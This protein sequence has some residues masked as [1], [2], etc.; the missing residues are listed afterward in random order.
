MTARD[1]PE[2]RSSL[3]LAG[4]SILVVEDSWH[5]G[6][7]L[8]RVLQLLG[9][10]VAGP[11]PTI[12]EAERLIS[13]RA[14]DV[15]FVDFHL[16]GGELASG[17]IDQLHDQAVP[18]IVTTGYTNIPLSPGKVVAILQ[19]PISSSQLLATLRPVIA[20]QKAAR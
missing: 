11:A 1:G 5:V 13:E 16:R 9:A 2:S 20:Q 17:L 3:E 15:A 10:D 8:K 6:N 7:A 19:K 12:A 18:V 14:P 4:L